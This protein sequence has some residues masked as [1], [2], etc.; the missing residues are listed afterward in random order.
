V[1]TP[2]PLPDAASD[3]GL[4]QTPTGSVTATSSASA[5][6]GITPVDCG[7]SDVGYPV[8]CPPATV[9]YPT[10]DRLRITGIEVTG[11]QKGDFI[12]GK[13]CV[14]RWLNQG[15][16]CDVSIQ[17]KPH[18]PGTRTATL[19]IHQT[20]PFPDTGTRIPVIGFGTGGVGPGHSPTPTRRPEG[21]GYPYYA[22][23]YC[24][25][26]V[27]AWQDGYRDRAADLSNADIAALVF[28]HTAPPANFR[29]D[30]GPTGNGAQCVILDPDRGNA[31]VVELQVTEPTSQAGA[32]TD[33]KL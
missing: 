20:L 25:E 2:F 24:D 1:A 31:V 17:F 11:D 32:I 12:P 16:R 29:N 21:S 28:Q 33:A 3:A 10:V 30:W 18:G 13:D 8:D 27:R 14:G 6:A 9:T 5:Y 26:F 7:S 19:V 4:H 15:E 22:G 23:D